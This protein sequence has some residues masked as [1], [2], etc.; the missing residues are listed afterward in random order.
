MLM[1]LHEFVCG[2]LIIAAVLSLIWLLYRWAIW[3]ID[4]DIRE[5]YK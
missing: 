5:F 2:L 4:R 3:Y 1:I